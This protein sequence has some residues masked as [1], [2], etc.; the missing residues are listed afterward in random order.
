MKNSQRIKALAYERLS[1][2]KILCDNNKYDGAFYLAGYSVELMLKMKICQHFGVDNLFDEDSKEAD[3][4]SI[5]SVRNAV[6]IHDIKRLLIFSGLKNKFEVAKGLSQQLMQTHAYLFTTVNSKSLCT[7]N[8]QVRYQ[9]IG[10]QK[11]EAVRELIGLLY[12]PE[13]LLEWINKS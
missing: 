7:W 4:D 8:E 1:E 5:A 12:H 10:S 13:G 3:K 6:K 9:E 2:A 11:A